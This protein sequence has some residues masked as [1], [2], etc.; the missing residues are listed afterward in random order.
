M[1]DEDLDAVARDILTSNDRGGYTIPTAGLY[2]FQWNWDSAFA[3]WGFSTFDADRAW[4]EL[5]TLFSAQWTTGMVPHIVFH[6]ED[7]GYFPGPDVWATGTT[8]ATSGISQPP[9]AAILAR[10][11]H[12]SVGGTE[13]LR[14]LYPKLLAWHR[15]WR[16]SRMAHG[17][18]CVAH[19]WESGRDNCPDWDPGMANVDTTGIG[20]YQR[21]DTGHV[22]AAMRPGKED[23]DRYLAMVKFGRDCGWD[24]EKIRDD[25]PFLMGDPAITFILVR[26]NRDLAAIAEALGEDG[27]VP[28]AWADEMEAALP[29]LWSESLQAYAARDVRTGT[30]AGTISSGAA[31]GLLAGVEN[32]A[33]EEKL[34][35]M[36][37]RVRY[38]IPSNDPATPSFEP[39]RYWR[40]PT[41]PV[42]NALIAV[43]LKSAGRIADEARLRR[44]TAELIRRGGFYEYF[45]PMDGTACG[46]DQ[47]TWTAAIWL[48]WA[49]REDA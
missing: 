8:P 16:E 12:D 31:L 44:E 9:V 34:A 1:T 4:T 26:A 2:P 48:A 13:R 25:G 29:W 30:F 3:A 15:W 39:R 7:D 27:A 41:W 35:A 45:D 43:G 49:N 22:D 14:A 40:G 17:I 33:M 18:A 38:G 11:I 32:A 47:F 10:L 6:Q 37:D 46:G 42:V 23:Y 5:E 20:P 19:P 36:W 21:R 24:Q 28:A